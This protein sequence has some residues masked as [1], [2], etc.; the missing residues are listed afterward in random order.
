MKNMYPLVPRRVKEK[1]KA[2]T[3]GKTGNINEQ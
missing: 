1:E 3:I 2:K